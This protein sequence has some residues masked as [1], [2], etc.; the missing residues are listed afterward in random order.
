MKTI[1]LIMVVFLLLQLTGCGFNRIDDYILKNPGAFDPKISKNSRYITQRFNFLAQYRVSHDWPLGFDVCK[2]TTIDL[3]EL[4]QDGT[5]YGSYNRLG[6]IFEYRGKTLQE[7]RTNGYPERSIDARYLLKDKYFRSVKEVNNQGEYE[8]RGYNS[9]CSQGFVRTNLLIGIQLIKKIK[10]Y[11]APV[12]NEVLKNTVI[13]RKESVNENK[14]IVF[15]HKLMSAN[16]EHYLYPHEEWILPVADTGYSFSFYF[17]ANTES[18]SYEEY[19]N[20]KDI[21]RH[22][23]ES[24]KI[25]KL[26]KK[27]AAKERAHVALII[28]GIERYEASTKKFN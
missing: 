3:P 1:R 6:S 12:R 9:I 20:L 19:S 16:K 21:F 4:E 26:D 10:S 18:S 11:V 24:V 15:R 7:R 23:I 14:W 13:R 2:Y 28:K 27:E 22:L 17:L 5:W 25:E 8:E